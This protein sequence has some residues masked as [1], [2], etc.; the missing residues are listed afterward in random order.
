MITSDQNSNRKHS[1]PFLILFVLEP[2]GALGPF[3]ARISSP[4]VLLFALSDRSFV[5]ATSLFVLEI[6]SPGASHAR[7]RSFLFRCF[8]RLSAAH[9][10]S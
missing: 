8:G 7:P 5:A 2:P 10:R 3:Y 6:T 1:G 4:H 9:T